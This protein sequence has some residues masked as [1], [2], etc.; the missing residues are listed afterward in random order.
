LTCSLAAT[1]TDMRSPITYRAG[2]SSIR[3]PELPSAGTF[4]VAKA[5][6]PSSDQLGALVMPWSMLMKM[7]RLAPSLSCNSCGTTLG[8]NVQTALPHDAGSSFAHMPA[9]SANC[10]R[11]ALARVTDS[12][13]PAV[14]MPCGL[15]T[16]LP[17]TMGYSGYGQPERLK[18]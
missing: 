10:T 11:L 9:T 2:S 6:R 4:S 7:A 8:E 1:S 5:G 14:S 18:L 3:S 13:A 17:C 16:P 12:A 15:P